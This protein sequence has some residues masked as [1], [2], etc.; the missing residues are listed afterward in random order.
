MKINKLEKIISPQY[1]DIQ[2]F[3]LQKELKSLKILCLRNF[4]LEKINK[5]TNFT[6]YLTISKF[7]GKLFFSK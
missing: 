2:Q 1:A 3:R 6:P 5:Q 4:V 7:L